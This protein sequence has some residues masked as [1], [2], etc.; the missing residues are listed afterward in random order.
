M[1]PIN[2]KQWGRWYFALNPRFERSIHG[3]NSSSGFDFAPSGKISCDLT[4][5]VAVG[6]EYY[7]SLGPVGRLDSWEHQQHQIFPTLDLNFS[8]AWEFNFGVGFGLTRSTDDLMIKL[9]LGRRF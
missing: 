2:D 8:P 1:R 3:S 6:V 9:I 7:S 5:L 4:K